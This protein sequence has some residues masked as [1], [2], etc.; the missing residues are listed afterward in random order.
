MTFCLTV[1]RMLKLLEVGVYKREFNR[2]YM[3]KPVCHAGGSSFGS[4]GLVDCYGAFLIFAIGVGCSLVLFLIELYLNHYKN[5]LNLIRTSIDYNEQYNY[6][7]IFKERHAGTYYY[8]IDKTIRSLM[9]I[10]RNL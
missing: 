1:C 9:R 8:K 2:L 6:R 4:A 7:N 3:K 5:G 10:N